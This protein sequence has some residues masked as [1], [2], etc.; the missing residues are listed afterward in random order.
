MFDTTFIIVLSIAFLVCLALLYFY[1][2][3][4]SVSKS[5][6]DVLNNSLLQIQPLLNAEKEKTEGLTK[7]ITEKEQES[8]NYNSTITEITGKLGSL[9]SELNGA[10]TTITNLQ[11]DLVEFKTKN[12]SLKIDYDKVVGELA[13]ANANLYTTISRCKKS[14]KAIIFL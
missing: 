2:K 4:N 12:N 5:K 13:T 11:K 7:R 14:K 10:K 1:L 6:F 9:E 8:K 3:S